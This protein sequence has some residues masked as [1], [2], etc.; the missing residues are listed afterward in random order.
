MPKFSYKARSRAGARVDGV[1]DVAD[2]RAALQHLERLG[3]VPIAVN[4]AAAAAAAAAPAGAARRSAPRRGGW[5]RRAGPRLKLRDLLLFTREVRDLL[6]SG[7][8][9]GDTL[10]TLTRHQTHQAQ[11][12]LVTALRDKIIEGSS[13]SGALELWPESFP[14]L[15]VS[16]VRAGE[17]SGDMAAV[18]EGLCRHYERVAEAREKVLMAMIYP[19]IILIV[20]LATMLFAMMFVV[21]RFVLVFQQLGSKLPLPTQILMGFSHL[22]MRWGWLLL[23]TVIVLV[24]LGRRALRRPRGRRWWDG[25]QLHLPLIRHIVTANAYAHF[26]RTL[27]VLLSNGVP[28]LQ[29]LDIVEHTVGN[30][31]LADEIREA[32]NRVTDGTTISG[33]LAAGKIFPPLLTDMLAVGEKTGDLSGALAHIA[34]RYD[35]ELDRNIKIFTSVLEPVMILLMAV[36]VGFI[37]IS[38]LLAVFD[39]TSGLKM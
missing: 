31:V 23:L 3:L 26:A 37:A 9:L 20:G 14:P 19:A 25:R 13:L 10:N 2:R 6:A 8:T 18:L 17:A 5:R 38:L 36:M 34:R 35:G 22:L 32:R 21:P 1:V 30:Q 27:G 7:M 24:W 11:Q 4:A 15:Y 16:M 39:M 12:Q 29:A 28:V 33:P